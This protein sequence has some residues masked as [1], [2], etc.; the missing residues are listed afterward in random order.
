MSMWSM[1]LQNRK[2]EVAARLQNRK[3][4]SLHAKDKR[5]DRKT[6]RQKDWNGE[7]ETATGGRLLKRPL[8][9]KKGAARMAF[10]L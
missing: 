5:Q 10:G 2:E 9:I 4:Q 7:T 8:E 1:Q 6:E 3:D